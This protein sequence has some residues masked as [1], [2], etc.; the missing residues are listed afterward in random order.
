S[1]NR[2]AAILRDCLQSVRTVAGQAQGIGPGIKRLNKSGTDLL[3]AMPLLLED[4]DA[5]TAKLAPTPTSSVAAPTP[6]VAVGAAS[7]TPAPGV[8]YL[9]LVSDPAPASAPT[10]G[11]GYMDV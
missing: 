9:D 8:G 7:A 2:T 1:L 10:T 5:V 6:P 3:G 11:V 4:A